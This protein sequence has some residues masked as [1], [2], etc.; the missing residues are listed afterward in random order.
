MWAENNADGKGAT[1]AFWLPLEKEHEEG[2]LIDM[3]GNNM[4]AANNTF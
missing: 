4:A 2:P 1:F 3:G